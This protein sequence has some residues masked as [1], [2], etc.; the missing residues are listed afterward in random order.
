M[1]PVPPFAR[2][3]PNRTHVSDEDKDAGGGAPGPAPCRAGCGAG[4][5]PPSRPRHSDRT[6]PDARSLGHGPSEQLVHTRPR[7]ARRRLLACDSRAGQLSGSDTP[8]VQNVKRELTHRHLCKVFFF[9]NILSPPQAIFKKENLESLESHFTTGQ[10]KWGVAVLCPRPQFSSWTRT[11]NS[12]IFKNN[13]VLQI[14]NTSDLRILGSSYVRGLENAVSQVRVNS[15]IVLIIQITY[16]LI[17]GIILCERSV[18]VVL[19]ACTRNYSC[20]KKTKR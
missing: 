16:A 7:V 3:D 17:K 4:P 8:T 9:H 11:R 19:F 13:Q 20:R 12:V 15:K 18:L 5:R 6:Q 2:D 14:K 1:R 10:C